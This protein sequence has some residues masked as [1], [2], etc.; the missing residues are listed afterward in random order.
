MLRYLTQIKEALFHGAQE[1][2]RL[3]NENEALAIKAKAFDAFA[4][5]IMLL[6]P[7]GGVGF[8]GNPDAVY[9]MRSLLQKLE[10]ESPSV[11]KAEADTFIPDKLRTQLVEEARKRGSSHDESGSAA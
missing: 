3:R 2:E 6:A 7:R 1:I 4:Q 5:M 9:V 11:T 8:S 10:E